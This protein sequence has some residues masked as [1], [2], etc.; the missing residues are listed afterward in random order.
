MGRASKIERLPL[1][2]R[3][4]LEALL[5]ANGYGDY[6]ALS[7]ALHKLGYHIGKSSIH[8]YGQQIKRR[9]QVAR[10]R[11]QIEAAGVDPALAA[12]L[13]GEATLVVVI[14]RR[15]GRARLIHTPA[16]AAEVISMLKAR[17]TLFI[18]EPERQS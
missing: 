4:D 5:A 13:T 16:C 1:A 8:R 14:D 3:K 15:N 6:D 10:A 17:P 2:V 18:P 12:E 7:K 9:V 11:E